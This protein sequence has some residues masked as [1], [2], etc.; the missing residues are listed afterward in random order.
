MKI[1]CISNRNHQFKNIKCSP[2][3]NPEAFDSFDINIID[4][5]YDYDWRCDGSA[6]TVVRLKADF[7]NLKSIILKS[8]CRNI[9]FLLPDCI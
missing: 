7:N 5:T 4:L 2:L 8:K 1:Q 6:L 3:G 9:L